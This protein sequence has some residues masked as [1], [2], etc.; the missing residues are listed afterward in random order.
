MRICGVVEGWDRLGVWH[1]TQRRFMK[2]CGTGPN[3]S[4]GE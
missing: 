1:K 4:G 2:V 3:G